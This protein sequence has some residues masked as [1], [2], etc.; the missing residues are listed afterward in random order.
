MLQGGEVVIILIVALVV[1]GPTRLPA[2][3]RKA[4]EYA[5]ELRKAAREVRAGLEAEVSDLKAAGDELRS[6]NEEIR[7]PLREAKEGMDEVGISRLDWKGP[8]PISGPTPADAMAD[9]D[10]IEGREPDSGRAAKSE[11]TSEENPRTAEG[12]EGG[13]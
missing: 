9:L 2:L 6:V 1:L 12:D 8:K 11:E 4:G 13:T 5:S 3:A 7:K 10:E